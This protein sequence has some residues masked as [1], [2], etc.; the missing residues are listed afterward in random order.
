MG[1]LPLGTEGINWRALPKMAVGNLIMPFARS[2]CSVWLSLAAA[3]GL[4]DVCLLAKFSFPEIFMRPSLAEGSSGVDDTGVLER[5]GSPWSLVTAGRESPWPPALVSAAIPTLAGAWS[6]DSSGLDGLGWGG[7]SG[8]S[9][10][11]GKV[12]VWARGLLQPLS[13][14]LRTGFFLAPLLFL[15]GW[16]RGIGNLKFSGRGSLGFWI[17][18][19]EAT[20]GNAIRENVPSWPATCIR[21]KFWVGTSSGVE[22]MEGPGVTWSESDGEWHDSTLDVRTLGTIF[23]AM[24]LNWLLFCKTFPLCIVPEGMT[25]SPAMTTQCKKSLWC[26][27][28]VVESANKHLII[29]SA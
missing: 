17:G 5:F 28:P 11:E 19:A 26:N 8:W 20:C 9:G 10:G 3:A 16:Y 4:P 21:A 13:E 6:S 29:H 27:C 7:S 24:V 12:R 2:T 1:S 14:E 22:R 23:G 25:N 15:G 18:W